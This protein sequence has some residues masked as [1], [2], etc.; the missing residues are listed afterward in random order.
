MRTRDEAAFTELFE[1]Q[2]RPLHAFLLGRTSD[3]SVAN[4]LL[5]ETFLRAWRHWADLDDL[6]GGRRRAWLFTVARNLVVDHHRARATRAARD[7]AVARDQLPPDPYAPGTADRV[8]LAGQLADLDVA[9]AALPEDERAVLT[10]SVVAGM[11][12][13]DIADSLDIPAGTVRYRLHRART[14]L[15]RQL[16]LER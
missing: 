4:D 16:D 11:S 6:D 15:A 3:R 10:M 5:Q 12:S 7:E 13:R 14:R 8:A 2:R 1:E 9:I